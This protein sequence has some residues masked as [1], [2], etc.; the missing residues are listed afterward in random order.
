[1]FNLFEKH[2]K[3]ALESANEML[4]TE[5]AKI[6][7][8]S[9]KT[10]PRLGKRAD[11]KSL[12][13][14]LVRSRAHL[15]NLCQMS[16][17]AYSQTS[18]KID[19]YDV[20]HLSAHRPVDPKTKVESDIYRYLRL[21]QFEYS[22]EVHSQ[23][24]FPPDS[25]V[26]TDRHCSQLANKIIDYQ[27]A[28][29]LAYSA[30]PEQSSVMILTIIEVWMALDMAAIKLFPLLMQYDPGI[31]HDCLEVLQLVRLSD[32]RRLRVL[33]NYL[34]NRK[35]RASHSSQSVFGDVSKDCFSVKYFESCDPMPNL[36]AN[37]KANSE[38]ARDDK[39]QEWEDKCAEYENLVLKAARTTCLRHEVLDR[40]TSEIKIECDSEKCDKHFLERK[41]GRLRIQKYEDPLPNDDNIA[42]AVVFELLC[43]TGFACWRD[44]TWNI[45]CKLGRESKPRE[46]EP[47]LLLS[48]YSPL[49]E[50]STTYTRQTGITLASRDKS[51]LQTHYA[52]VGFPV[53]LEKVCLP[54]GLRLRLYDKKQKL[55]MARE[56]ARPS[57]VHH[58]CSFFPSRS[59]LNS[60]GGIFRTISDRSGPTSNEVISSQT[61]CPAQTTVFEYVGLQ[62]LSVG[63]Q[64][65]W[66]H[67]LRELG[68][69]NVNFGSTA[70]VAFISHL[71]LQVGSQWEDRIL[72]LS[73][74][75]F[76]DENFCAA[77]LAQVDLRLRNISNNW[78]EGQT[79]ECLITL[80]NRL[81]ELG[82]SANIVKRA[83]DMLRNIRAI[84]FGWMKSLQQDILA[85]V[86]ANSAKAKSRDALFAALLCRR[87]FV[88]EI[89]VE[90]QG[91]EPEALSSFIESSI[92]LNDNVPV[93]WPGKLSD[94]PSSL[95]AMI[96][97]DLKLVNLLEP[98]LRCSMLSDSSGVDQSM[99]SIWP[100]P[101]GGECRKFSKWEF[102]PKPHDKWIA[103]YS[104]GTTTMCSQSIHYNILDG[105]LLI[106]KQRL[107]RLPEQYSNLGLFRIFLG[108]RLYMTYPSS[109]L[110]MSYM[111]ANRIE[112]NQ[113]HFGFR[114]KRP[115]M[116]AVW[117]N[118]MLELIPPEVF[119][120][121]KNKDPDLPRTLINKHVHWLDL[122][123]GMLHITP[124]TSM[125]RSKL[126]DWVV[127]IQTC[128]VRRRNSTLVDI[129]SNVYQTITRIF[130][131]FE[132]RD[133]IIVFQPQKSNLSVRLPV[134][135]LSFRVNGQGLLESQQLQAMVDT[136]QDAGTLYGLESK[137]VL[138]SS[139]NPRD[140]S[141]IVRMGP[142]GKHFL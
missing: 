108:D 20:A 56:I 87:T 15:L 74:W 97:R 61:E 84:T 100:Q 125:W 5:W 138:R 50:Y 29:L 85:S 89:Y 92:V 9:V 94:L 13:L 133:Q 72:R 62:D 116:R 107:R 14:S 137:L 102:L 51:F 8:S 10:I 6:R 114:D 63:E 76:E 64:L 24:L 68:S 142:A 98:K 139:R 86:D 45:I 65:R 22:V 110:G 111:L 95:R 104:I 123:S 33:Q 67:I 127:D 82:G 134:L 58:C 88:L 106:D 112:G 57:F 113:V 77:L 32:L 122:A 90:P 17:L 21:F 69:P 44:A 141:I 129:R 109:I 28:A 23:E 128:Q 42:K 26:A 93:S 11:D 35:L 132:D 36:L 124:Q 4:N 75:I 3:I 120:D 54:N 1:M 101:A 96:I 53:H 117:G 30:N 131:P 31:P 78:R 135:D 79:L 140:R 25:L 49:K 39:K 80:V 47:R 34:Q 52:N 37:I 70:T 18:R 91:L 7:Q 103:A 2:F 130:E 126:S 105:S 38:M 55:W 121:P 59:P 136:N 60:L 46:Q 40:R 81:W 16:A 48:E 12:T 99:N 71:T 19:R 41:A 83:S 119:V 27:D 43:P 73:H 118:Q 66:V 115:V